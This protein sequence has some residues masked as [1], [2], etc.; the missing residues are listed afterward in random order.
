MGEDRTV[1][2][3]NVDYWLSGEFEQT[4]ASADLVR[5]NTGDTVMA[6]AVER[7]KQRAVTNS[8]VITTMATI[9]PGASHQPN[10]LRR[11]MSPVGEPNVLGD[12]YGLLKGGRTLQLLQ[13]QTRYHQNN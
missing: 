8:G 12:Q 1:S 2:G 6:W 7:G 5:R 9:V 11:F 10:E 3:I 4:T 13:G